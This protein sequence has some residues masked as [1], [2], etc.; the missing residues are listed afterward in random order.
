MGHLTCY[1]DG[2]QKP[3][4]E[5]ACLE[6]QQILEKENKTKLQPNKAE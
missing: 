6:S 3:A 1:Y 2:K 4:Q 5:Q